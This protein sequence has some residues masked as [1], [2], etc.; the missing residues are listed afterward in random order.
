M[1]RQT[2]WGK[3]GFI[4]GYIDDTRFSTLNAVC[5]KHNNL[6]GTEDKAGYVRDAKGNIVQRGHGSLT[7]LLKR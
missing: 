3:D 4:I 5:D 2:I 6:L 1:A 7:T